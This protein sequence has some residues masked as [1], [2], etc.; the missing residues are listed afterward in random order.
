[1]RARVGGI[2]VAATC[3]VVTIMV[4]GADAIAEPAADR[5][6]ADASTFNVT[7]VG[8]AN[9]EVSFRVVRCGG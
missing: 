7:G 2:V 3:A 9:V 1:V 4:G 5:A 8:A 6:C